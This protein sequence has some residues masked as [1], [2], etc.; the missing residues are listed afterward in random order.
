M[1][2]LEGQ[3]VDFR[4]YI[5]VPTIKKLFMGRHSTQAHAQLLRIL[6]KDFLHNE[7]L[8]C[9]MTSRKI[10]KEA[11]LF[12]YRSIRTIFNEIQNHPACARRS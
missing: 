6:L 1:S 9:Y 10:K 11:M 7:A 12:N 5:R 8:P 4:N 2:W 3:R